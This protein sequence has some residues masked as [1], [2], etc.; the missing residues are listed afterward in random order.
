MPNERQGYQGED[1]QIMAAADIDSSLMRIA[2]QAARAAG[3]ED[4]VPVGAVLV[5]SGG[6]VVAT[7]G[8]RIVKG[9]DPTGHAEIRVLR[10]AAAHFGNYRLNGTTLYVTLEPCAMCA[11]AMVH[12]RIRRLV[13][14][15]VDP[16]AGAVVSKYR[17]GSDGLLNHS[18][19]VSGGVL[20]AECGQLLRDFFQRRRGEKADYLAS[21]EHADQPFPGY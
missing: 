16:K 14:G 11:A 18:F 13:F 15:A 8:N 3:H 17:L 12:A 9:H 21:A 7:A 20:A 1:I 6:R 19:Q 2:L 4:E 10:A 5:D